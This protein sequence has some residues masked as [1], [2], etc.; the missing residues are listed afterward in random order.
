MLITRLPC[1]AFLGP[2]MQKTGATFFDD[3][4]R[5]CT[6]RRW[7]M[8]L[9]RLCVLRATANETSYEIEWSRIFDH[10][11]LLEDMQKRSKL[12][13]FAAVAV[14]EAQHEHGL[15]VCQADSISY[16]EG[17]AEHFLELLSTMRFRIELGCN[18]C[19]VLSE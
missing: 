10:Q 15:V 5:G 6:A 19:Q 3:D 12:L 13:A 14:L 17:I 9:H 8:A 4:L 2:G 7:Q 11:R 18:E 1:Y 16:D